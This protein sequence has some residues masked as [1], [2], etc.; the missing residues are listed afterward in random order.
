MNLKE[1]FEDVKEKS[2]EKVKD[3]AKAAWLKV[4]KF[5][6]D[7]EDGIRTWAPVIVSGGLA[8]GKFAAKHHKARAE[9]LRIDCRHWDPKKGTYYYSK[10][11]L[12]S[13]ELLEL[14]YWYDSGYSKGEALRRMGL[15]RY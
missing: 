11:P 12:K 13:S 8:A 3:T 5:Y 7:H 1:K 15:L 2:K 14:D 10:R 6:Y 9:R 4:E